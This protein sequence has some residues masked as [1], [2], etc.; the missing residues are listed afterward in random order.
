MGGHAPDVL[1][2][3]STTSNPEKEHDWSTIPGLGPTPDRNLSPDRS[4]QSLHSIERYNASPGKP[5]SAPNE[6][7]D[8]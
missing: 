6:L 3:T 5:V 4:S 7:A 8:L 2:P 1:R